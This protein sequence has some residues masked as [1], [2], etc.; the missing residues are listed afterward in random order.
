MSRHRCICKRSPFHQILRFLQY[1]CGYICGCAWIPSWTL[2]RA[3]W[4]HSTWRQTIIRLCWMHCSKNSIYHS[5]S[6]RRSL[7]CHEFE[8]LERRLK[9]C[10]AY[11]WGR[12]DGSKRSRLNHIQ[13]K[14]RYRSLDSLI[15]RQIPEPFKSCRER[16][17]WR[18]HSTFR[19]QEFDCKWTLA[20]EE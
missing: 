2:S 7:L 1:S 13:R 15:L 17:H 18:N 5:Q 9:L 16:L 20:A 10:L 6:I 4:H 19:N 8:T 12:C 14:Q 11:C 3:R